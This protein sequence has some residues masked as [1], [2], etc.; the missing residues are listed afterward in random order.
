M[1]LQTITGPFKLAR[2]LLVHPHIRC[3]PKTE[4]LQ[5]FAALCCQGSWL[6]ELVQVLLCMNYI[7][8]ILTVAIRYVSGTHSST[9]AAH[10][11]QRALSHMLKSSAS[12][13]KCSASALTAVLRSVTRARSSCTRACTSSSLAPSPEKQQSNGQAFQAWPFCLVRRFIN[14][15]HLTQGKEAV[16]QQ[17]VKVYKRLC[18]LCL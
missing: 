5:A 7:H 11:F 14:V 12:A 16:S 1:H 10:S 18:Y 13:V 9:V 3:R 2:L 17:F 4:L 8:L 15:Q 6:L